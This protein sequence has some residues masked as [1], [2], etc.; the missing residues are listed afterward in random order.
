MTVVAHVIHR[1]GTGGLENGMV[2]LFNHFPDDSFQHEVICLE[3]FTDFRQRI[4]NPRVRFHDI[5]KQPGKDPAHYWRLWR[6]LR[7]LRPDILHSRNLSAIEAQLVGTLAG[8]PARIHGEHGRD[9]F[10]L[11][12]SN[13][14]YNRLRRAMRP[15]VHRYLT[16]S[17]DLQG[18][19]ID[20]LD[21]PASRVTQIYN[22][23]DKQKFHPRGEAARTL[24]P[25]HWP[26]DA[27]VIGSVGR[28]VGVKDYPTLVRAFIAATAAPGAERARLLLVGDG[29]SR[30][31]CQQLLVQAG[32]SERAWLAG[33][34][35]DIADLMRCMDLFVLPSL[36]EG[37]SNTILEAMS[38]ALPVLAT[39]VGGNPEL[40]LHDFNGCL[41]GAG[42]DMQMCAALLTY[43][44]DAVRTRTH[45]HASRQ[46]I[47]ASF[48]IE[49]MCSA[50]LNAYR[51]VRSG[52]KS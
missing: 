50:Y 51:D 21:V 32:L 24:L 43:V 5:A 45:G 4:R 36:G 3:G 17:K 23:V 9:V 41:V 20:M 37:I 31:A 1:F 40:V 33:E 8:V 38:C 27:Y 25:S 12:G 6:L 28:M 39:R 26:A 19:L 7:Q 16:V 14:R 46:R 52:R 15:L 35:H 49:A 44:G 11:D 48:S 18:W 42:D 13:A 34:R 47:E 10:D 30:E 29:P 22:G 2:N